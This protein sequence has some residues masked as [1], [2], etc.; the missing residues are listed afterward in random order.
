MGAPAEVNRKAAT[1]PDPRATVE[2]P[3]KN[4][5]LRYDGMPHIRVLAVEWGILTSRMP[6]P[7][8]KVD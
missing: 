1:A 8:D 3:R 7:E 4:H 6:V 5:P 2:R